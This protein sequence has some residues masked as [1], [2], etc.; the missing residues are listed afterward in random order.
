MAC[1]VSILRTAMFCWVAGSV[2]QAASAAAFAGRSSVFCPVA[3]SPSPTTRE[4]PRRIPSGSLA[5]RERLPQSADSRRF[6]EVG[7]AAQAAAF[8]IRVL[9]LSGD[10]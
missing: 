10:S 9:D 5:F 2:H 4:A 7:E 8:A 1:G 3:A 6:D